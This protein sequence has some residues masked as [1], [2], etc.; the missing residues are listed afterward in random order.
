MKPVIPPIPT[1]KLTSELTPDKLLRTTNYGQNEV[2]V[3]NHHN[4]PHVMLEIGRIREIAFREAGGGTGKEA[5]I[6]AYDTAPV[7][8]QQL[9]VWNPIDNEM[10]GGYRFLNCHQTPPEIDASGK[11]R[12]ATAGLL[13]FSERFVKD[14]LPF[15]IELGRS[16]VHPN[17]QSKTAG[18]KSL[19][20]L[21][22]LW[23]GLGAIVVQDPQ[24]KYLFGKVTMYTHYDKTARDLLLYFLRKHF[25]DSEQLLRP[26]EAIAPV[27][28]LAELEAL[29]NGQSYVEDYKLLSRM[30]RDMGLSIP[31][32]INSYMNLSSTMRT[33]GTAINHDF[34]GVEETGILVTLADIYD[35]K[36]ERHIN[37]YLRYLD[38]K[39]KK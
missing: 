3:V 21:D 22:N 1:D 23:D 17:Y 7:P 4:A 11:P 20:A 10:L 12:L 39:A 5:D 18:R 36:K 27:T 24:I 30:V 35:T 25:G 6:D 32:L 33:F 2:Y 14:Y 38:S 37:S 9:V 8:Y 13:N 29:L 19:F 16:F 34:G 31:P 28:P 26:I 15:T